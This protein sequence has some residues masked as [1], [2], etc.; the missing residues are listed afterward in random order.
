MDIMI[1]FTLNFY[2]FGKIYSNMFICFIAL[3]IMEKIIK[4]VPTHKTEII[5]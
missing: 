2:H 4:A 1:F 5:Q 3:K